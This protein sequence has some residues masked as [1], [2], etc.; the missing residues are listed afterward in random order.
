MMMLVQEDTEALDPVYT[1]PVLLPLLASAVVPA[2]NFFSVRRL[3]SMLNHNS[4]L[5]GLASAGNSHSETAP[6]IWQ[7]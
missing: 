4:A 6:K 1:L 7:L 2:L 3:R 5:S